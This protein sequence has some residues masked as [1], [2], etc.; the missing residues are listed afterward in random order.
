M[1]SKKYTLYHNPRCSKSR[2]TL[3]YLNSKGIDFETVLYLND[4]LS[5]EKIE[6]IINKSGLNPSDLIRTKE[7]IW[8]ELFKN[9]K[10]SKIQIIR[11]IF[12]HP[13]LMQRP[14]F[15][16]NSRAVIANPSELAL[17]IL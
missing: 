3:N 1:K 11:A 5:L 9:K 10:L 17:K 7:N 13:K 16:S 12:E 2:K 8:K 4:N 6:N 14:V 15:M